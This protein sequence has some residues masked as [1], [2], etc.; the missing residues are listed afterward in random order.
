MAKKA[1]SKESRSLTIPCNEGIAIP[2]A[3]FSINLPIE[4]NWLQI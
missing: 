2:D 3:P 4:D 1:P